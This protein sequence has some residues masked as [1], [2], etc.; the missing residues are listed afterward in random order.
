MLDHMLSQRGI[1]HISDDEMIARTGWCWQEWWDVL[2]VWEGDKRQL[3]ATIA[4]L[5]ERYGLNP[6]WARLIGTYYLM[7][8]VY[9]Q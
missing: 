9:Q 5:K 3:L 8:R 2:D 1:R 6:Y 7:E 4:Y